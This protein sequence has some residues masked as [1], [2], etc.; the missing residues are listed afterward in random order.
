MDDF[1]FALFITVLGIL[2]TVFHKRFARS[3]LAFW[4]DIKY[5]PTQS[6]IGEIIYLIV[7]II[8]TVAGLLMIFLPSL[9]N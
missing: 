7:G 5:T 8:F 4:H 2:V 6:R 1:P 3:A 9:F